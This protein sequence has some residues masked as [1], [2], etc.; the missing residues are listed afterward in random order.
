MVL[1]KIQ[2][3]CRELISFGV[4]AGYDEEARYFEDS[5]RRAKEGE[6]V[7]RSQRLVAAAFADQLG[8]LRQAALARMVAA[9]AQPEAQLDF[10]ASASTYAA[11]CALA[12]LVFLKAV[13]RH[14]A[15]RSVLVAEF[16]TA[17]PMMSI[18][19]KWMR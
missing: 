8:L 13:S 15:V 10:A 2:G 11:P 6:L 12:V 19:P 7:M 9:L 17:L 4:C 16:D 18:G 5:V 3:V 14:I 1:P